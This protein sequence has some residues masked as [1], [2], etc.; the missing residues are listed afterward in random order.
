MSAMQLKVSE[1]RWTVPVVSLAM[2][3]MLVLF[4]V[5]V[6]GAVKA[7]ELRRQAMAAHSSALLNCNALHNLSDNKACVEGLSAKAS[8]EEPTLFAAK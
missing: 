7:G 1:S 6:N 2:V 8:T 3:C 4:Y 5:V